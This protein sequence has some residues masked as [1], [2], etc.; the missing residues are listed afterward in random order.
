M[1]TQIISSR[2]AWL[3]AARPKTLPA[4]VGPVLVGAALA[5]AQGAFQL[6]PALACLLGA[7]LLQIG[8]NFANDY[9]DFFKGADTHERLGPLRVT[10]SGLL[11][12]AQV[13]GGMVAVFGAAVLVGIYLVAQGGWPILIVGVAAII[14]ALAYTGGPFPFGYYGLGDFFVFIFFGL[15]AVCGTY[16]VQ[17]LHLT[18][19]VVLAAVPAGAL[20]TNILVVNNLRD[21]ETDRRANKRTLAVWIGRRATQIEYIGL[22]LVAYLVPLTLGATRQRP[23]WVLLPWLTIPL[24]VGLVGKVF[25]ATDG[26]TLNATL[27]GTARLSLLF[28]LLFAL[29]M[30]IG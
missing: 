14:A 4:A 20:I 5:Y 17:A 29:S 2:Q 18:W 30:V 7:L 19:F 3:M 10:S 23:W 25:R 21:L 26:P 15:V 13:R 16:Y 22:L 11:T 12:P 1:T 6:V 9:F 8:S 28:N 24:A 27:A